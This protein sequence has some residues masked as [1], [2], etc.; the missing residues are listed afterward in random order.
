[1][2]LKR[3]LKVAIINKI[4]SNRKD[5]ETNLNETESNNHSLSNK[6]KNDDSFNALNE[7]KLDE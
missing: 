5:K 4:I 3:K 1:M 2:D 7:T 6:N